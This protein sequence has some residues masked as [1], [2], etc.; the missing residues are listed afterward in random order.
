MTDKQ[1][2]GGRGSAKSYTTLNTIEVMLEN[3]KL[4]EAL[5][6][7]EQECEEL[8]NELHK[9]FEEKDTLHLII[10]R[11]LEAS[12]YDTN[13]ASAEE[14][15]DVYE[16]MRYEQQQ[17]DQLKA[18]NDLAKQLI[19]WIL[20]FFELT[21]YDWQYDQNEISSLI[22][23]C[24]DDKQSTIDFVNDINKG[25][26]KKLTEIKEIAEKY[27]TLNFGEQ[28]YCYGEILQKISEVED[29]DKT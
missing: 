20:K 12:G 25:L 5:K 27:K 4:K 13:T 24:M 18:E 8:K 3:E 14:F 11:L 15:E 29:A 7:K 6:A 19:N 26:F 9:N 2:I 10:D 1:I 22:E 28:Q 23:D 21:D 16:H 17:L